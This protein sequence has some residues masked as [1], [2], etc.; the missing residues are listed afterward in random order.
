M[1][2]TQITEWAKRENSKLVNKDY[3]SFGYNTF[4]NIDAKEVSKVRSDVE[5]KSIK[6]SSYLIQIGTRAS[7][8]QEGTAKIEKYMADIKEY[9][10]YLEK[11]KF[12][13]PM[14]EKPPQEELTEPAS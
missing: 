2:L 4:D 1:N 3:S 6:A 5:I 7:R 13:M 14:E 12:R 11:L 10:D 9:M 8:V